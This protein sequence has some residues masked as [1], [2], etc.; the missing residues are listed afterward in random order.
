MH[1][2][3]QGVGFRVYVL[4]VARG[5]G[6]RGWVANEA[7]DRVRVAAEGPR[8]ALDRLLDALRVGP[9]AAY[10][11]RVVES[12]GEAGGSSNGFEIRSGWHPGD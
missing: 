3:V 6:L 5:L 2:R 1:G 12:W 8:E 9:P 4:G 10:V 7:S 11:E